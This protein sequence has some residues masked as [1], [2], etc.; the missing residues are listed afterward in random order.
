M[1]QVVEIPL[2]YEIKNLF[3]MVNIMAA[4]DLAP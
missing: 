4:D 1:T 3:H 2:S